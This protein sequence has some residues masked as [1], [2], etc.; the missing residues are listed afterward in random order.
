[1]HLSTWW[2][3]ISG[4]TNYI[5]ASTIFK[6][7][8]H[9]FFRFISIFFK[10]YVTPTCGQIPMFPCWVAGY[11]TLV[12]CH[13][14][15]HASKELKLFKHKRQRRHFGPGN[16]EASLKLT[17]K[18]TSNI[19][20]NPSFGKDSIFMFIHFQRLWLLVSG[21]VSWLRLNTRPYS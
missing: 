12:A 3:H 17:A 16:W 18:R 5:Y 21:R 2:F 6:Q 9:V 19:G 10:K 20:P 11:E 4:V 8:I 13:F 14:G 15:G 7:M 1:M